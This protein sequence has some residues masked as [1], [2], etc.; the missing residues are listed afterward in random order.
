MQFNV[1]LYIYTLL[2]HMNGVTIT[3]PKPNKK[4]QVSYKVEFIFVCYLNPYFNPIS[5]KI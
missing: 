2:I 1:F 5:D 3:T 4:I